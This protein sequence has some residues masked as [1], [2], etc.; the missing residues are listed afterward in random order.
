M[1]TVRRARA[2]AVTIVLATG[3]WSCGRTSS[4]APVS[5]GPQ[6]M[7]APRASA[8]GP[9]YPTGNDARNGLKA[10]Y[11][12]AGVAQSGMRL[13]SFTPKPVQFDTARGLT[14]INS[15][16]AFRGNLVYQA[17]RLIVAS[18]RR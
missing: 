1:P 15:D 16:L 8:V 7:G 12:D 18:H 10:G 11:L 17:H 3:G 13:V 4:P 14:F 9:T 2:V 6:P 5:S